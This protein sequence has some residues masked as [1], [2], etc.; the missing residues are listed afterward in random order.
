[1]KFRCDR[2]ALSEALADR[3]AGV[4]VPAGDP[5]AD[6]RPDRGGR[7]RRAHAHHDRPRG[8]GAAVDRGPGAGAGD[9]AGAGAVARRHGEVAVRTRP[10]T[11]ET[12]QSQATYPLR[13]VR[14]HAAAAP[15]RG[16]PGLAGAERHARSRRRPARSPRP[17]GQVA[18]GASRDE[19][20]PVLT[21]VLLEVS[22]EGVRAGRHRLVPAGR[23]RSRGDAPT[24]RRRRSC[25]S[26]R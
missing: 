21:G 1:M 7:R 12:D 11:F 19:A 25:P 17:I 24:A 5:G 3:P 22:R 4:V 6:R 8:L 18:R 13:G 9:R 2:D 10:S 23:P 14:G 20:R 16:L 26:G 15:R